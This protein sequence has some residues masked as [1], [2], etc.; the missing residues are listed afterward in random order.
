MLTNMKKLFLFLIILAFFTMKSSAQSMGSSYETAVGI[1]FWPA[2]VSVKHFFYDDVAVE[3]L[4]NLRMSETELQMVCGNALA[5][6][7]HLLLP[8][9]SVRRSELVDGRFQFYAP[10]RNRAIPSFA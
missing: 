5:I 1:K 4:L 7:L 3:G 9:A 2:A 8:R 10:E 6:H